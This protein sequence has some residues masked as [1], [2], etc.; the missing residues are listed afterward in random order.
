MIQGAGL[1]DISLYLLRIIQRITMRFSTER[2]QPGALD[3][4]QSCKF[5]LTPARPAHTQLDL[6]LGLN[7][8]QP[9]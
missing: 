8:Y 6:P 9:A 5:I 3:S 4:T 1:I 2:D 7:S